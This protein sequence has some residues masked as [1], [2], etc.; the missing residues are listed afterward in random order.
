MKEILKTI[1]FLKSYRLF[2][3]HVANNIQLQE[4]LKSSFWIT[5]EV[6]VEFHYRRKYSHHFLSDC[7]SRS[8]ELLPVKY[9][10]DTKRFFNKDIIWQDYWSELKK[11]LGVKKNDLVDM[12]KIEFL[13]RYAES[14]FA[15]SNIIVTGTQLQFIARTCSSK[16]RCFVLELWDSGEDHEPA[17]ST[18]VNTLLY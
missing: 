13:V 11:P 18:H 10:H 4:F 6:S 1:R 16:K 5:L 17:K 7:K 2:C 3:H 15:N 8:W 9:C 12:R 14:I